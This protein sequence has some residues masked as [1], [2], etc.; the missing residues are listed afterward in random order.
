MVQNTNFVKF[1]AADFA[2]HK[3]FQIHFVVS[4]FVK[5]RFINRPRYNSKVNIQV[6]GKG[7]EEEHNNLYS[8]TG[9][10]EK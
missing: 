9:G 5:F 3:S 2:F 6:F 10:N 1:A 4:V 7:L 8:E